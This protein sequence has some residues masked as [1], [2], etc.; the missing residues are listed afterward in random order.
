[1]ISTVA[2]ELATRSITR[3]TSCIALLTPMMLAMPYRLASWSR[4]LRFSCWSW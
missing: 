4:R 3:K 2:L 1:V